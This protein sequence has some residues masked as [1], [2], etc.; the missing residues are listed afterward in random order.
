MAP[1]STLNT[2]QN[3]PPAAKDCLKPGEVI[4]EIYCMCLWDFFF[5][6]I[7]FE[8]KLHPLTFLRRL[9]KFFESGVMGAALKVSGADCS[10]WIVDGGSNGGVM[11][12]AG[13]ARLRMGSAGDRIP[14][15]GVGVATG[16]IDSQNNTVKKKNP[17]FYDSEGHSHLVLC[18]DPDGNCPVKPDG[19]I[20]FGYE[21][22]YTKLFEDSLSRVFNV[23]IV[24]LL[25]TPPGT[26]S[27]AIALR[28]SDLYVKVTNFCSW[29]WSR[30]AAECSRSHRGRLPS[31][32]GQRQ[33][34]SC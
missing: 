19:K 12:L 7:S 16:V 32:C 31:C 15:I 3:Q 25:G 33:W 23:P 2:D 4:I 18:V 29:R 34:P 6:F 30:F 27:S 1:N 10:A 11:K 24:G 26:C 28:I 20:S 22:E 13:N 17:D 5:S 21:I 8:L 14:L 9:V